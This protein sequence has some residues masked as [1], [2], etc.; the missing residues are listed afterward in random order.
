M[1]CESKCVAPLWLIWWYQADVWSLGIVTYMCASGAPPFKI[2][3]N[4]KKILFGE[5]K[6]MEGKR[7]D[8]VPSELKTLIARMLTVN[9][10]ER[11]TMK[12]LIDD[13]WLN[14]VKELPEGAYV[15]TR[16]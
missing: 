2:G 13:P 11:I 15:V 9:P 16:R 8:G 7:W 4:P 12:E 10:V 14:E 3:P 1:L 6:P 5:Y